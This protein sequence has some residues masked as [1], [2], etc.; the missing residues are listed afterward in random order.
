M[1]LTADLDGDGNDETVTFYWSQASFKLIVSKFDRGVYLTIPE[2]FHAAM[3]TSSTIH[4]V[5]KDVTKDGLPEILVASDGE[6]A[7]LKVAIWGFVG[8]AFNP[9]QMH[10]DEDFKL[11]DVINGQSSGSVREGGTIVMPCG[12]QG[13]YFEYRWKDGAF[14]RTEP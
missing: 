1:H 9:P 13:L 5:I 2:E 11:L 8:D 3:E 6:G 12:S 4:V 14:Q 7:D 10:S